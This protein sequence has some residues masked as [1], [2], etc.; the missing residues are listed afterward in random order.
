MSNYNLNRKTFILSVTV[1][2]LLSTII[3]TIN[4]CGRPCTFQSRYCCNLGGCGCVDAGFTQEVCSEGPCSPPPEDDSSTAVVCG[5][6]CTINSTACCVKEG[7]SG[8]CEEANNVTELEKCVSACSMCDN[9][10]GEKS[11]VAPVP[12]QKRE[13]QEC[14]GINNVTCPQGYACF[15]DFEDDCDDEC[16]GLCV[17][18]ASGS[19]DSDDAS[20][21]PSTSVLLGGMDDEEVRTM[22]SSGV[23]RGIA[24]HSVVLF[25]SLLFCVSYTV[26]VDW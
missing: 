19:D 23:M 24:T 13:E 15:T 2:L 8:S 25:V 16:M 10:D 17:V 5:G 1:L 21:S 12:E 26:Y 14:G 7:L 22:L 9:D 6:S 11:F 4:A 20:E 18:N 3:P